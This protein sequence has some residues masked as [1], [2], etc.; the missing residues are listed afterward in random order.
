MNFKK[1][2][3]DYLKSFRKNDLDFKK[4]YMKLSVYKT[5]GLVGLAKVANIFNNSILSSIQFSIDDFNIKSRPHDVIIRQKIINNGYGFTET[6]VT[7][8]VNKSTNVVDHSIK[9]IIYA[10][11]NSDTLWNISFTVKS[12][13]TVL[14]NNQQELTDMS[15]YLV[16][17]IIDGNPEFVKMFKIFPNVMSNISYRHSGKKSFEN[18]VSETTKVFVVE[19][20]SNNK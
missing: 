15:V 16:K 10:I 5:F 20:N 12:I 7:N 4:E 17:S 11:D 3:K 19:D 14:Y 8:R 18:R 1:I 2:I 6:I 9:F 13:T